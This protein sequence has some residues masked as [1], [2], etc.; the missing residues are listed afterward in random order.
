MSVAGA[1]GVVVTSGMVRVTSKGLV[2]TSGF[3]TELV[4][5]LFP[6]GEV[7]ARS[8]ELVHAHGW[9]SGSSVVLALIVVNLV[10]GNGGVHD[11]GLDGLLL[12]DGLDVLMDVVV[13][14]LA[15]NVLAS[16]LG[17]LDVTNL[18]GALELALLLGKTVFDV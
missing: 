18:S 10:H 2:D 5:S 14:V 12:H 4:D 7:A 9:E 3:T 15:Y 13:D 6:A 16:T 11:A 8:L 1:I 17:V